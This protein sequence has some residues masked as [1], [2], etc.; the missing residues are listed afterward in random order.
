MTA[1]K[2]KKKKLEGKGEREHASLK[3][4]TPIASARMTQLNRSDARIRIFR[5][6]GFSGAGEITLIAN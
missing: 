4:L 5:S 1:R 3:L 2:A 6:A